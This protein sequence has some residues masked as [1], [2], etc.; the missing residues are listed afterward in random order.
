[1]LKGNLTALYQFFRL[2]IVSSVR[3]IR[4]LSQSITDFLYSPLHIVFFPYFNFMLQTSTASMVSIIQ[5]PRSYVLCYTKIVGPSKDILLSIY[6]DSVAG[7]DL[8][9]EQ[10]K[11]LLV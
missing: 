9:V 11:P 2:Y 1:M 8:G 10:S 5:S 4:L 3:P 6:D 7:A